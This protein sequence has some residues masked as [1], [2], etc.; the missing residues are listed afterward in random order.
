MGSTFKARRR[1][2]EC[3]ESG[4]N[5][6]LRPRGVQ[7]GTP[8]G[9]SLDPAVREAFFKAIM[10]ES[11]RDVADRWE[12]WNPGCVIDSRPSVQFLFGA[13]VDQY[14]FVVFRHGGFAI[15]RTILLFELQGERVE[16]VW[17]LL[18][19]PR[20]EEIEVL[21]RRLHDGD[22]CFVSPPQHAYYAET[23]PFQQVPKADLCVAIDDPVVRFGY[24]TT[25]IEPRRP[26]PR[27]PCLESSRKE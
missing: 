7:P 24:G 3:G 8:R 4:L 6:I 18:D 17:D 14:T 26:P 10:V 25:T 23:L 13:T 1:L 15:I 27:R 19:E 22:P 21:L 5:N 16:T 20:G 2:D 9:A 11:E 12:R